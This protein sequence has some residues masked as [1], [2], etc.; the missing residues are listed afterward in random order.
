M[1]LSG[2]AFARSANA[3]INDMSQ[4]R[5]VQ[6]R[7]EEVFDAAE[8]K[9]LA[10]LD[11]YHLYG[12][13]FTKF[14]AGQR[15]RLDATAGRKGEHDGLASIVGLSMKA[16]DL[17]IDLFGDTAIA[18]FILNYNFKAGLETIEK[19]ERSTLVWLASGP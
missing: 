8:K 2:C 4:Q 6:R 15:G 5:L 16:E 12:P 1:V 10:R 7:L 3:N 18:T 19:Q 14:D 11:S 17:K 9:A 13:K